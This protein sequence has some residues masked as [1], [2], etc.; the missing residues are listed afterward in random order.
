[1]RKMSHLVFGR[2]GASSDPK[3]RMLNLA[4]CVLPMALWACGGD[5]SATPGFFG[6]GGSGGSGANGA[7]NLPCDVEEVVK[8]KCQNCHGAQPSYGSP[9]S[10]VTAGDFAAKAKS[11]P[12][13]TV[14]QLVKER[15][16]DT[17]KPMPPPPTGP[18]DATSRATL[19]AWLGAGA[20]GS[21]ESCMTS[22]GSSGTSSGG[23][24]S[25][26][27][28]IQLRAKSP[29]VMPKA[30]TDEYVC[31]GVDVTVPEKRHITAI[32]PSID[33][34]TIVHHVLLYESANAYDPNP[35]PCSAGGPT[36]GRLVSV[37]AP[38]G[39]PLEFPQEAGMPLEGTKHYMMQMHY[40][41]LTAL[42]GQ[43]DLSGFD[44]CTTTNLRAND[45]DILAFGT[46]SINV[47]AHTAVDRTCDL[48]V[49]NVIPEIN[50]FYAMPHMHKIG[51][52]ISGTVTHGAGGDVYQLA[53]RNPWSF[54]DQYWDKV[55]TTIG[56][57]DKVS[58][59]CAWNNTTTQD[60]KFGEKTE[61]EMCYMFAAYWPRISLPA[62]NWG[63]GAAASTCKT[64]P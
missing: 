29:W 19:D 4:W 17:V 37:W 51:T 43:T 30:T 33:N 39:Q 15:I 2:K 44:L 23:M 6:Y 64:T 61:D 22:T 10:L 14:A 3:P 55:A 26:T 24:L 53:S 13:K 11:D 1:M 57:G 56:P 7:A 45:A 18:L 62:W 12:S 20:K 38:G 5:G 59:R 58:V 52:V 47:P 54:D 60:V 8:A 34:K 16:Y 41:N 21:K 9:M 50:V 36:S 25:C 32:A 40:S 48:T 49:P 42:D 35:T 27:P 31:I 63:A 46:L 28:D